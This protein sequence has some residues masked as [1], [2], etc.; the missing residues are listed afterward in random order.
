MFSSKIVV[1]NV[2]MGG[3][4]YMMQNMHKIKICDT[5]IITL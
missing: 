2:K 4:N 1:K 3:E 5:P